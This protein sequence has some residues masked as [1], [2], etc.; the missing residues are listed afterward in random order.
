M[1]DSQ[2]I[3]ELTRQLT[4]C[5]GGGSRL[6][7]MVIGHEDTGP[8]SESHDLPGGVCYTVSVPLVTVEWS[9]E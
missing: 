3:S 9:E 7:R 4:E 1:S 6:E 2:R 5:Q 8:R